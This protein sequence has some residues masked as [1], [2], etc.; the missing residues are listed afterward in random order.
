ML[1]GG[2]SGGGDVGGQL[3]ERHLPLAEVAR[4]LDLPV[5]AV[6]LVPLH[7][8]CLRLELTTAILNSQSINQTNSKIISKSID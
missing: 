2:V 6:P 7:V 3:L 4:A 1:H 8:R 5:L